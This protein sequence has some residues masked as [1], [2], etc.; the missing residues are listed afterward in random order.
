M[1]NLLAKFSRNFSSILLVTCLL[2]S[3]SACST[4]NSEQTISNLNSSSNETPRS[5]NNSI[6]KIGLWQTANYLSNTELGKGNS[7]LTV[8]VKADNKAITF[9]L[10]TDKKTVGEALIENNLISGEEGEYGLYIKTVNG[11]TADYN[12]N[13]SYWAFYINGE[14]AI[15]GVDSTE[16]QE[17]TSYQLVYSK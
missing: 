14:Y 6:E 8:D 15:S 11:I 16:I 2:F 9:T 13:Q 7:T 1:K 5:E 12:I 4:N 10:H 17:N 3:F